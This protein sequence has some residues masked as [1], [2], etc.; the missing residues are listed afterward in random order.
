MASPL[1]I[2]ELKC[3]IISM[4]DLKSIGSMIQVDWSTYLLVSSM[5]I[6]IKN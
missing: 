4:L 5:T 3:I 2:P 1:N 6:F